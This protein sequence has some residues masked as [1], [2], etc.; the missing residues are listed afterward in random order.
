MSDELENESAVFNPQLGRR[1]Q[2]LNALARYMAQLTTYES[3]P[4]L[5]AEECERRKKDVKPTKA[6]VMQLSKLLYEWNDLKD[7]Q[8][9]LLIET[10][11]KALEDIAKKVTSVFGVAVEE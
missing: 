8:R 11:G 7:E 3:K 9:G 2:I 6:N 5:A 10:A 4:E 1:Q